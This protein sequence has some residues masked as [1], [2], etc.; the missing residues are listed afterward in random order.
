MVG[1]SA[2]ATADKL[3]ESITAGDLTA[4]QGGTTKAW[5]LESYDLARTSAYRVKPDGDWLATTG[6]V[7]LDE[8]YV[9]ANKK[10]VAMQLKKGGAR[11]AQVLN[12]ALKP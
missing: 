4:W 6:P 7:N 8:V 12:D 3:N 11:L 1:F 9:T 5:M 2:I 10:V